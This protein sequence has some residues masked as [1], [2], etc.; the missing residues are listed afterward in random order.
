MRVLVCTVVHHP[1][2]ARIYYR[3]I[4]ALLDAGHDVTYIAPF[5]SSFCPSDVTAVTIPRAVGRHR[6]TAL[7]AA[8]LELRRNAPAADII[9]IHDPELLLVLPPRRSRPPVVW[10]VHEDT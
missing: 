5:D 7:R 10:D 4:R 3:Q 1:A 9:L 2:D 6:A 8:R